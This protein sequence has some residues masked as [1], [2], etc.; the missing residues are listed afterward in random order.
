MK[1][2]G[3]LLLILLA[4]PTYSQT[5]C[6]GTANNNP[7]STADPVLIKTVPNGKLFHAGEVQPPVGVM[8]VWGTAYEMGY[9]QGLMLKDQAEDLYAQA[10]S[11][12]EGEVEQ[13]IPYLPEFLKEFIAE[14]GLEAALDLTYYATRSYT[15]SYFYDELRGI[16]D[17]SGYDY[18]QIVRIHMFPELIQA[19]CS[20]VGAW[21]AATSNTKSPGSLYQLRALDWT[22]NGPFQNFPTVLVYHPNDNNGHPFAILTFAGFVGALTGLSSAPLGVCEKVWIH[23]NGTDAR[24]GYPWH[25]LLRE[26][27]QYSPD[28]TD[29]I[30]KIVNAPRTCSIFVGL[31]DPTNKFRA[32]EYSYEYVNIYDDVNYPVYPNHPR[33][34][35]VVYIDKHTQPSQNPCLSSLI[36]K[37]YGA[38]DVQAL[39]QVAAVLGTGDAH[40][41]IY[42][43]AENFMY[44]TTASPYINGSFTPAYTRSW[45]K[46]DLTK[47]FAEPRPTSQ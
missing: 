14:Y 45:T 3:L 36:Q 18:N 15:P 31:G 10:F 38:L 4:Y 24:E 27:L 37:Y 7:I 19:A 28:V 40:A 32:L 8:H 47:A 41:A 11:F 30:S 13:A 1:L 33:Y 22:T 42:D 39:I 43:Y 2:A 34:Q 6:D 44:V 25:F 21:G 35:N 17:G 23:Y 9:A 26:I 16:A 46:I 5:H 20:M 29:A 12:I